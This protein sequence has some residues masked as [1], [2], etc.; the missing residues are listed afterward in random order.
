[1]TTIA[2][3]CQLEKASSLDNTCSSLLSMASME[4]GNVEAR[5]SLSYSNPREIA[6]CVHCV[7][8]ARYVF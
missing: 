3:A 6:P 2:V 5:A 1:M 8:H 7:N 4:V